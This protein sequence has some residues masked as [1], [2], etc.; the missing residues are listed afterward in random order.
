MAKAKVAARLRNW[1]KRDIRK[2]T[3][4]SVANHRREATFVNAVNH[5]R[6]QSEQRLWL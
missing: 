5:E 4:V 2:T 6:E 1:L 3:F